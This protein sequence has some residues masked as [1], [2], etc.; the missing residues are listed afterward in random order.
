MWW[1]NRHRG[2]YLRET[3]PYVLEIALLN[4][5]TTRYDDGW[6]HLHAPPWSQVCHEHYLA[7]GNRKTAN[8]M[9]KLTSFRGSQGVPSYLSLY[10]N[11]INNFSACLNTAVIT[12]ASCLCNVWDVPVMIKRK[13]ICYDLTRIQRRYLYTVGRTV[14][15][16]SWFALDLGFI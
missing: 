9:T 5:V 6:S 16:P 15:G 4:S 8:W 10:S 1:L 11:A 3:G 12:E 13:V 14:G 7:P 2:P